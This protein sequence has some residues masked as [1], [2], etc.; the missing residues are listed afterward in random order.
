MYTFTFA[1]WFRAIM[2]VLGIVVVCWLTIMTVLVFLKLSYGQRLWATGSV[3][4]LVY[5]VDSLREAVQVGLGFRWRLLFMAF[6]LVAYFAYLLEPKIR[7]R[8][9]FGKG[10]DPLDPYCP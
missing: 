6:G 5:A 4:V 9:R 8:R 2:V 7:K 10:R 3:F 1:E